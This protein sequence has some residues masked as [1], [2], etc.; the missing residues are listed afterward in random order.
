MIKLP[1]IA[2]VGG[3]LALTG[4]QAKF[5]EAIATVNTVITFVCETHTVY[6]VREDTPQKLKDFAAFWNMMVATL[7][8][9]TDI[10]PV[11]EVIG[12]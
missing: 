12:E 5:G 6:A 11:V 9:P 7:C 8:P 10:A 1:I 3:A 4:C 2:A